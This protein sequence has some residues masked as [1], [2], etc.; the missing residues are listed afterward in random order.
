MQKRTDEPQRRLEK[1]SQNPQPAEPC[2]APKLHNVDSGAQ[3]GVHA[4]QPPQIPEGWQLVPREPTD[5]ML[6]AALRHIDGMA[7]MPAAYKAMLEAAPK[8]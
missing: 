6:G 4:T 2:V 7:C 1:E 8:P 5:K 3:N